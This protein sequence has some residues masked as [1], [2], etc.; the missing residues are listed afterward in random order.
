MKRMDRM[1]RQT[2]SLSPELSFR[3]QGSRY[4]DHNP[5]ARLA[6]HSAIAVQCAGVKVDRVAA[7]QFVFTHSNFHGESARQQKNKLD[8]RMVVG[9]HLLFGDGLEVS[10]I[11]AEFSFGRGIVEAFKKIGDIRSTRTI[12]ETPAIFLAN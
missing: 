9:F 3:N 8:A 10:L 11:R 4:C 2:L 5:T 1:K 6:A 12:R 7:F